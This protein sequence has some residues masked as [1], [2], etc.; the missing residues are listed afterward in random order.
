M[1]QAPVARPAWHQDQRYGRSA[2]E[3]GGFVDAGRAIPRNRDRP[4]AE[5]ACRPLGLRLSDP[6][7]LPFSTQI[8]LEF[9][10]H[11][12]HVEERLPAALEVSIGC[13]VALSV[14]P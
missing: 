5:R 2:A 9:G 3:N 8:G 1:P 12:Q 6:F 10:K 14:T 13:S 7:H 4:A 11:A